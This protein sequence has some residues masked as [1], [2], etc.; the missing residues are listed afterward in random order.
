LAYLALLAF[1][2]PIIWGSGIFYLSYAY[3]QYWGVDAW[4][5]LEAIAVV[6]TIGA[7]MMLTFFF[8]HVYL[9]TTGHTPFAHIKT[10][11]T[12]WEEEEQH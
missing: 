1:V 11:I 8:V 9:T 12:G 10:M 5:S 7:F 2:S 6:H 4:L 3:W